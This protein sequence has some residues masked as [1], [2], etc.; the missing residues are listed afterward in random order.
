MK[1]GDLKDQL[2][3]LDA[4]RAELKAKRDIILGQITEEEKIKAE[5]MGE[6]EKINAELAGLIK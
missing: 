6:L 2:A 3:D 4:E 1:I 5:L